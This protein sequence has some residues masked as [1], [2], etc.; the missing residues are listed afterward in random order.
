[1]DAHGWLTTK[2]FLDGIALG[3]ITPGPVFIT[4]T[5]VGYRVAGFVGAITAT[6]GVFVPSVTAIILMADLHARIQNH[7][8]TRAIIKGLQ[9]GFIGL[10]FSVTLQFAAKS[11]LS[12]P[13][14]LIFT[15]TFIYVGL[16]KKNSLWAIL[17][18]V[19]IAL[20]FLN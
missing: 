20:L 3:Q 11:L 16:L 2:E 15:A 7:P 12:W 5:F 6:L 13:E 19:A 17:A 9:A 8:A 18:T 4:A 1:V 10:I 14:W